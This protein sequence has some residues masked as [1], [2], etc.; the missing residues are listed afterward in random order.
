MRQFTIDALGNELARV[1]EI[2]PV[3]AKSLYAAR[4]DLLC[5]KYQTFPTTT[6]NFLALPEIAGKYDSLEE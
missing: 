1:L 6:R 3:L 4:F 5:K 2:D